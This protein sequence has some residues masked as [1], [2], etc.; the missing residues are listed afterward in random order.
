MADVTKHD[1]LID[2]ECAPNFW[3]INLW[4]INRNLRVSIELSRR[5]VEQ[6]PDRDVCAPE[7]GSEDHLDSVWQA[8]LAR[9]QK[10]MLNER[11][12][13]VS[14]NGMSYDAPMIFYVL[15]G[16]NNIQIKRANDLIIQSGIKYWEAEKALG[17]KIPYLDH[18]DLIEPNPSVKQGQKTLAG[19]LHAP[20]MQDLPYNPDDYLTYEQMD[21]TIAYCWNDIEVLKILYDA[22]QEPQALRVALGKEYKMDFRS[23]SDA[24]IGEAI[25]KH[26]IERLTGKKPE[27]T[28]GQRGTTFSYEVPDW[29]RFTTPELQ[30]V[31]EDV[32]GTLFYINND[33]KVDM[34]KSLE[35]RKITIG[36]STYAMGIGGLHSTESKRCI[37]SDD[38]NILIDADVTSQYPNIIMKLGLYPKALGPEFL[39]VYGNL[40]KLRVAA[41]R[42]GDK[43]K[44]QGYKIA[45]NA[46]YGKL[47]SVYSVLYAPH[48]MISVTLTGQLSLLMLI[49]RAEAVGIPVVSGNT[50]GVVFMCPRSRR[51]ELDEIIKGWEA[52]T[53]FGMET[54]E[55]QS[56]YNASVNSYM[57]V[58]PDGKVK[59]KGPIANPWRDGDLR[60]QMMKNPQMTICSDAVVDF[61]TKGIPVED[62]IR[63]SRDVKGFVTVTKVTGGAT[64]RGSYLGK[65]VRFV[66]SIDGDPILRKIGHHKTGTHG[67][68][69]NTDGCRPMMEL[70]DH[71]PDDIDYDRY[72]S[73]AY[74]ILSEIGWVDPDY[75]EPIKPLVFKTP[76]RRL[77]YLL[78]A[79]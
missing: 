71:F 60:G 38:D 43:V 49:E 45:L 42:A 50:D 47:G 36:T 13:F 4:D 9:L 30:A 24:Q 76:V 69:P 79:V 22:L 66:W 11:Y 44:D 1:I 74:Q 57:A 77:A 46:T 29:M 19:R 20:K 78:A 32:R 58:K 63:N 59:L 31:L 23:K 52:D 10:I 40:I 62:T 16:K 6:N 28:S 2:T 25:I 15:S 54:A 17:I 68:V 48:L 21:E 75:V 67:K 14:F 39:E 64:W 12:R 51:A 18:I 5:I 37:H 72:I 56:I 3:L 7:D 33:G 65:V 35:G 70:P 8:N 55:Y 41:K 61:L 34:P 26:G 73:E 27:R 53:G